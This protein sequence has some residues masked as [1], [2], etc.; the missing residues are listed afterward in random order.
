MQALGKGGLCNLRGL[1][2]SQLRG[3]ISWEREAEGVFP[4]YSFLSDK[5]QHEN[6]PF[7]FPPLWLPWQDCDH[8]VTVTREGTSEVQ[9]FAPLPEENTCRR[10]YQ[11]SSFP[12]SCSKLC[13]ESTDGSSHGATAF[14]HHKP[15]PLLLLNHAIL[16]AFGGQQLPPG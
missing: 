1:L 4:A 10:V 6:P 16:A 14:A 9:D 2:L 7:A 15:V 11:S 5:K 12:R 13:P 3:Q 8:Q